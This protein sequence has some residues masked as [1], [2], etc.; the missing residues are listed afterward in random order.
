MKIRT[1]VILAGGRGTRLSE[2]TSLLPKP[3]VPIGS[4]PILW[5]IMKVFDHYG[6]R[7]FIICAG[8]KA[9][10]VKDFFLNYRSHTSD[11]E[12][13]LRTQTVKVFSDRCEDWVVS[14][15]D[16]GE[17]VNTGGRLR[18][19]RNLV[20]SEENFFVTYGDGLANVDL[21][22]LGQFHATRQELVTVT[23]VRAPGRFG[24][25]SIENDLVQGFSE[26][27]HGDGGWISG[28]FFVMRPS[29]LD[30]VANDDTS[31]EYESLP[32]LVGKQEVNAFR[33]QGFWHPMDTLRDHDELNR[34]WRAG[35]APWKVW[36]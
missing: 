3:M 27:P 31:W 23:A 1:A 36:A 17:D 33:H 14:V 24:S 20:S 32:L 30:S 28:G 10:L 16:T 35:S 18:R 13:D 2:M 22:R 5:H 29:A 15:V 9:E 11:L 26:K 25:L 12:I 21:S 6:V 34:L 4:R 8:Y 19:I 7:R